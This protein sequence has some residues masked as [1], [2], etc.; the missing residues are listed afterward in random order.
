MASVYK[1]GVGSIYSEKDLADAARVGRMEKRISSDLLRRKM[2]G[3]K[4]IAMT[5]FDVES[6]TRNA[7]RNYLENLKTERGRQLNRDDEEFVRTTDL[8]KANSRAQYESEQEAGDPNALNLS[9]EA[10]KKLD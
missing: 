4:G 5:P 9:F 8:P 10:W 6:R 7:T 1:R 3:E 2:G